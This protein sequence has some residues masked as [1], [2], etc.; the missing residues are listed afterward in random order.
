M[1]AMDENPCPTL[2]IGK[3][4]EV[5]PDRSSQNIVTGSNMNNAFVSAAKCNFG[6]IS[7]LNEKSSRYTQQTSQSFLKFSGTLQ[8]LQVTKLNTKVQC[9][10][11][12]KVNL[13]ANF[14]VEG[15]PSCI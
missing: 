4:P 6:H 10:R 11:E 15:N 7:H 9:E 3:L 2:G 1:L 12:E 14:E 13:R 5:W 8:S